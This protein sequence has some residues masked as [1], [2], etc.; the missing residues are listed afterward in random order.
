MLSGTW[1]IAGI[2]QLRLRMARQFLLAFLD[3][4]EIG[5]AYKNTADD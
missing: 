2:A 3:L 5:V 1:Q 4:N